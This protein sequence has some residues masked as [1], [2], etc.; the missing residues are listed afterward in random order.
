MK[1]FKCSLFLVNCIVA[2]ECLIIKYDQNLINTNTSGLFNINVKQETF[3]N[4]TKMG[5]DIVFRKKDLDE[6]R[7]TKTK[8]IITY[9]PIVLGSSSLFTEN[10]FIFYTLLIIFGVLLSI[11]LTAFCI[12]LFYIH[13]S[14]CR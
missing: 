5:D 6:F 8:K 11:M 1:H 4:Q 7:P 2:L 3:V 9:T 12:F 13:F 14:N 10:V